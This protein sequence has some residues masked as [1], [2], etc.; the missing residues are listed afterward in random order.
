MPVSFCNKGLSYDAWDLGINSKGELTVGNCSTV[1]LAS[2]YGT[3]L[4]I[5]PLVNSIGHYT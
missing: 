5:F 3:P 2:I 4:H 1:E